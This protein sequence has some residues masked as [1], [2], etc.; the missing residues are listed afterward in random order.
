MKICNFIKEVFFDFFGSKKTSR[1]DH[2]NYMKLMQW[3]S[4][5]DVA[6]DLNKNR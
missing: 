1:S 3:G 4:Y 5:S 6:N 2:E